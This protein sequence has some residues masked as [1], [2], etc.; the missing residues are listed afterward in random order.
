[1]KGIRP[2]NRK[3]RTQTFL[4]AVQIILLAA[5]SGAVIF[6]S[7]AG[8]PP[9]TGEAPRPRA[10]SARVAAD[11]AAPAA[12]QWA[13]DARLVNIRGT[14]TAADELQAA[15]HDWS[16][17][18]YSPARQ[19][20]ALFSL[21]DGQATLASASPAASAPVIPAGIWSVDS[22]EALDQVLSAGGQSFLLDHPEASLVLT[23]D[24]VGGQ[25][26]T[27]RMID[28]ETR[29]TFAVEIGA[30]NGQVLSMR[31]SE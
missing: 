31:R 29:L 22:P 5:V 16:L 24:L 2:S 20:T 6:F 4:V 17:V 7:L 27:G 19:A 11:I 23:L 1:M 30:D 8:A 28:K 13:A 14:W 12:S 3:Q 18:Y 25:R 9:E 15:D 26:W 21:V 10:I